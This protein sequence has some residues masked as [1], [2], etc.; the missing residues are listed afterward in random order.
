MLFL[1]SKTFENNIHILT[2]LGNWIENMDN[3]NLSG[4]M[5]ST[6]IGGEVGLK[7]SN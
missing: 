7:T 3:M 4:D 6:M 1:Q 2:K 5:L